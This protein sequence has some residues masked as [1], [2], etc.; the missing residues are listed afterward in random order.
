MWFVV[1]GGLVLLKELARINK[2]IA[3]VLFLVLPAILPF[4]VWKYTAGH[5]SSVGTWFHWAKVCQALAGC[6]FFG[7]PHYQRLRH[8]QN[9]CV[10]FPRSFCL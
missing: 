6:P 1:L 3:L 5:G 2:V 4:T 7:D 10:Y 8:Q 9:R